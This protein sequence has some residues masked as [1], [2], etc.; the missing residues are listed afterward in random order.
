VLQL[1]GCKRDMV[2]RRQVD[3]AEAEN[4]AYL[5]GMSFYE[6]S[7]LTG[8]N[9]ELAFLNIADQMLRKLESGDFVYDL[10]QEGVSFTSSLERIQSHPYIEQLC[11]TALE[12]M[13]VAPA[14][15]IRG[16]RPDW[17]EMVRLRPITYLLGQEESEPLEDRKS[18]V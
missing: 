12:T 9:V 5:N 8:E 16:D 7:A 14:E 11:T 3:T 17:V 13:S 18:V 15:Q 2:G 4:W 1:V 6:T 10:K